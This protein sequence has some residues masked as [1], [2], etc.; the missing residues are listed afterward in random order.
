MAFYNELKHCNEI[1]DNW[2]RKRAQK[3]I[4]ELSR[5]TK[6]S[7]LNIL[8]LGCGLGY[9]CEEWKRLGNHVVGADLN[10]KWLKYAKE[11]GFVDETFR[12]DLMLPIKQKSETYDIVY[13]SEV[14]EHLPKLGP[15]ISETKRVLKKGGYLIVTTDNPCNIRNIARMLRQDSGYFESE[16]HLHYYSPKN[17][18]KIMANNGFQ[19]ISV[20][21]LGRWILPSLGDCYLLIAKK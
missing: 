21:T 1:D 13:C 5:F 6:P 2:A 17:L 8:D 7:N 15:L 12:C 18:A 3:S 9:E 4:K 20:K 19:V 11:H 10:G 16:G 14:F